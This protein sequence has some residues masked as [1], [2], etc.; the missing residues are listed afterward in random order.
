MI[1]IL[2]VLHVLAFTAGVGGGL[3]NLVVMRAAAS[4]EPSAAQVLRG[5]SPRIGTLS[6]HALILLWITGPLLLWLSY[7]GGAGL[8]PLFS[9][10]IASAV[11]LTLVVAA[12]RL[13]IRRLMAGKPAPLAPYMPRLGPLA[14]ALGILTIVLAV[15]AFS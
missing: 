5:I 2:T 6:V 15:L 4:A 13:T 3:A 1:E 11:L 12:M 9:A 7:D 8:G 14:S 10:K